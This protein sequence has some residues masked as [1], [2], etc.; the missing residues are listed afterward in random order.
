MRP[1]ISIDRNWYIHTIILHSNGCNFKDITF[2]YKSFSYFTKCDKSQERASVVICLILQKILVCQLKVQSKSILTKCNL[3][4]TSNKSPCDN[5]WWWNAGVR[6]QQCVTWLYS[7]T[8]GQYE[9]N[10]LC[11]DTNSFP[12]CDHPNSFY[13]F[14][15]FLLFILVPNTKYADQH[16]KVTSNIVDISIAVHFSKLQH[17]RDFPYINLS[18][19]EFSKYILFLR[20]RDPHLL[21]TPADTLKIQYKIKHKPRITKINMGTKVSSFLLSSAIPVSIN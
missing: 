6:S 10:I 7:I 13:Y 2:D 12:L 9:I 3:W 5:N 18:I 8:N 1:Y 4:C 20:I 16:E 15:H 11:N 19:Y 14:S 17:I 21:E